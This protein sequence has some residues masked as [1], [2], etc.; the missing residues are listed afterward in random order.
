MRR[1]KLPLVPNLQVEFTDRD[2]ALRR[3]EEW[4]DRGMRLVE[5]VY[6][7]EGCGK[8]AWLLQSMELLRDYGFDVVYVNPLNGQVYAE[9][10]VRDLRNELFKLVQEAINQNALARIAWIAYNVINEL[11]RV[12][13]GRVAIL[14]D[15]VFQV[16]GVRESA[17]Y[18]KA[19]LNLIEYPPAEYERVITIVTT[20]EGLSRREIGRHT[21]AHLDV[22]WNMARESFKQLY[23]Q[24]PS[25]KLGLE[26][27]WRITGGNPRMLGE[28]ITRGWNTKEVVNWLMDSK[29][30]TQS[31]IN[32][33]RNWLEKAI[34]NPDTLWA[35]AP[36][37]LIN[38]LTERN[39]IIHPL[40][41]RDSIT[42]IDQPPPEKDLE[43]GIG[44]YVAWQTPLHREAVRRTLQELT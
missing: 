23:S 9:V 5:V 28:L 8:T 41:S 16:I 42:W 1:I 20:S 29:T 10:G 27:A 22:M 25:G 2:L 3:V 30:I 15:D 33:W 36:E 34:E 21:W 6:G 31:F 17:M 7:P 4:V 32:K 19:L 37:E 14:A 35:N 24:L 12:R 18:V 26:E 11:I 13:R 40:P 44:K 43:L 38:E 39:L